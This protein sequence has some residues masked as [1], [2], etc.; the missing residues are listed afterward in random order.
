MAQ[1]WGRFSGCEAR[2][3]SSAMTGQGAVWPEGGGKGVLRAVNEVQEKARVQIKILRGQWDT[4]AVGKAGRSSLA[5]SPSRSLQGSG[6]RQ[7]YEWLAQVLGE[8][9]PSR[10]WYVEEQRGPGLG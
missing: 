2:L 4:L 8:G 3:A 10:S 5:M 9:G 7:W 6:D 1:G